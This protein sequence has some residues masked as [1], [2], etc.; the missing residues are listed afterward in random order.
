MRFTLRLG[1]CIWSG[2]WCS[3][4]CLTRAPLLLSFPSLKHFPEPF[5]L[6]FFCQN[7]HLRH[8]GKFASI[9]SAFLTFSAIC[10]CHDTLTSPLAKEFRGF[11]VLRIVFIIIMFMMTLTLTSSWLIFNNWCKVVF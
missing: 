10:R 6:L 3:S 8:S 2:I 7:C 4:G 5:F 11:V 1:P 9:E